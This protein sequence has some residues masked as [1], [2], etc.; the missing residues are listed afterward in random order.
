ML[1][2]QP[3]A[4]PFACAYMEVFLS[5]RVFA[6]RLAR[7]YCLKGLFS[8]DFQAEITAVVSASE[9][10]RPMPYELRMQSVI[11]DIVAVAETVAQLRTYV[12]N[13]GIVIRTFCHI[14]APDAALRL[15]LGRREAGGC[16][17][18]LRR[19]L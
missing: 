14:Y 4:F 13:A 17:E 12:P 11:C 1:S 19:L 8:R 10:F 5:I 2:R 6:E 18:M 3:G 15:N 16:A 9:C 7:Q